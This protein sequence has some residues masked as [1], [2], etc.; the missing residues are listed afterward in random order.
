METGISPAAV[1][2]FT[3]V[4]YNTIYIYHRNLRDFGKLIFPKLAKLSSGKAISVYEYKKLHCIFQRSRCSV[5]R[6]PL[7]LNGHG[8]VLFELNLFVSSLV[9]LLIL[10]FLFYHHTTPQLHPSH[11]STKLS[12]G[13]CFLLRLALVCFLLII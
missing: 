9:S 13:V 8:L 7:A 3:N 5:S 1:A 2:K 4:S 6:C 11:P 10:C 12:F